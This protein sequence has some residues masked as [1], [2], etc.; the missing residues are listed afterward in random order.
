MSRLCDVKSVIISDKGIAKKVRRRLRY[1]EDNI[2]DDIKNNEE[3]LFNSDVWVPS[4][5]LDINDFI[6]ARSLFMATK[7]RNEYMSMCHSCLSGSLWKL[8]FDD[9]QHITHLRCSNPNCE[10]TSCLPIVLG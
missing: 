3:R 7:F 5:I 1:I 2:S 10:S 6:T 8:G 9:C 4:K